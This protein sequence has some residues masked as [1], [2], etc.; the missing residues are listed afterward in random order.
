MSKYED[1]KHPAFPFKDVV[2]EK[3]KEPRKRV[4]IVSVKLAKESSLLY[5]KRQIT[6]P[7]DAYA[8][9]KQFLGH[10]DREHFLV[11]CLSSK[12]TPNAIHTCHIGSL[13]ASIVH[14]RE[15]LK[16]A[17]LANACAIIVGH[18]HPSNHPTPSH[19]DIEITKRLVEAG[20]IMGI[21][22]LDHLIIC[23][24]TFASLKERGE[25]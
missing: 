9:F 18:N 10:V 11:L 21:E 5:E 22:V 24:D 13:N 16:P 4:D 14:P 2:K 3:P 6:G 8:L 23:D 12:N 25:M 20:N 19:E 17:I 7:E 1:K 15:V